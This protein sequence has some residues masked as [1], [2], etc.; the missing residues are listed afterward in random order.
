MQAGLSS[1]AQEARVLQV[2]DAG[3]VLGGRYRVVRF[4]ARGGMGEVYE[5]EQ[6]ELGRRVALKVVGLRGAGQGMPA[7]FARRF[8]REAT[9]VARIEH[10]HV[11]VVHELGIDGDL[12]FIAMELVEGRTLSELVREDG[13]LDDARLARIALQICD[14]LEEAH[15]H[16]LVHRD[17][18][19]SNILV[20]K[21]GRDRDFVKVVDFGLGKPT[22]PVMDQTFDVSAE[23]TGS[24]VVVG[25]P[26]YIAPEQVLG[27]EITP[28][29]DVYGVGGVMFFL[30][31][32]VPPFVRGTDFLT[33]SAHV[34]EAVPAMHEVAPGCRVSPELESVIARCLSKHPKDRYASAAELADALRALVPSTTSSASMGSGT[35]SAEAVQ[36][37]LPP[38][39][40]PAAWGA[41]ALSGLVLLGV[42][43]AI[44]MQPRG[45]QPARPT[46]PEPAVP[47]AAPDV[48]EEEPAA[49]TEPPS[50]M[51]P[52]LRAVVIEAQP[53]GATVRRGTELLGTTPLTLQVPE[54]ETWLLAVDAVGYEPQYREVRGGG[55]DVLVA[56]VRERHLR[57][58]PDVRRERAETQEP[59]Q[60]QAPV[61]TQPEEAE[62]P[63]RR[64]DTRDPWATE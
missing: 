16:G 26:H 27:N 48:R 21:R 44:M 18:K 46:E 8:Q 13:L 60:T 30:A 47:I 24:G 10:P 33:L 14:A 32:G 55:G 51:Q 25:S 63:R 35:I 61:Q 42:S 50:V 57:V 43:V 3:R 40:S 45:E 59:V 22:G 58:R 9:T 2:L 28:A 4:I 7:D 54:G 38:R 31:T 29:T 1:N 5:A 12:C 53:A 20:T 36:E 64:T 37:P 39:A 11:V 17:V 52:V 6:L 23:R 15:R 62:T 56:L 41:V 34:S 49:P 19:P